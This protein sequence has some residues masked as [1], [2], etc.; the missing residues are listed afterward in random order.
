MKCVLFGTICLLS[1]SLQAMEYEVQFE[2]D[3]ICVAKAK[4]LP[5]EEIGLHRDTCRQIIVALQGGT[6][7]RLEANGTTTDVAFPTGIAVLRD[8]DPPDE[9]H[10]S[11]NKGT[12]PVELIII[13]LKQ[14]DCLK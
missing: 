4:I 6:I 7:T 8:V 10:K 3:R 12:D 13:H 14:P 9:L 11:V 5:N 1:S 2:D